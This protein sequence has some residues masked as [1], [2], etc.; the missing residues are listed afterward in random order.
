MG[1]LD[2][3]LFD[4]VPWTHGYAH[5]WA[6]RWML[7]HHQAARDALLGLFLPHSNSPWGILP[8]E[9]EPRINGQRA[10]L[11]IV[12]TDG[13]GRTS[14]LIVETKVNDRL[15]EKQVRAYCQR[16]DAIVVLYGPGLT[17]LLHGGSEAFDREFWVTGREVTNTLCDIDLPD[18]I[19]SY[20]RGVVAQADR[21]DGACAAA[22]GEVD[23]FDRADDFSEVPADDLEAVAW[24]AET[25]AAMRAH[26]AK[27]VG[28]R[29]E[30]HDYGISSDGSV[31]QVAGAGKAIAFIEVIA[32][33]GGSEYSIT[34]KVGHG[35]VK[36]RHAAFEI[37]MGV[38]TPWEEWKPGK[39]P[40]SANY[41]RLWTLKAINMTAGEAANAA[42][43]AKTYVKSLGGA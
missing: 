28:V 33:H 35:T 42:L 12:A 39:S 2:V 5:S 22:R 24:V 31:V 34:I 19:H 7:D 9:R 21:M 23:D 8:V 43:R 13:D 15:Y 18:L 10:D 26:G 4:L 17:G 36:E 1:N 37:A 11:R 6:L 30:A 32:G 29:N 14:E 38:G 3:E 25:A 27:S 41:F 40:G 16:P 20:I